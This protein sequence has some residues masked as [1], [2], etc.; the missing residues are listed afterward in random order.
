M[1][2]PGRRGRAWIDHAPILHRDMAT[3]SQYSPLTQLE[4]HDSAGSDEEQPVKNSYS[5][6]GGG[7]R[8]FAVWRCLSRGRATASEVSVYIDSDPCAHC[9]MNI[10]PIPSLN[11]GITLQSSQSRLHDARH[12]TLVNSR[13]RAIPIRSSTLRSA[14]HSHTA[15]P[16][17]YNPRHMHIHHR[18]MLKIRSLVVVMSMPLATDDLSC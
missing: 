17:Q 16:R 11:E 6:A 9:G 3:A 13:G 4:E 18:L 2:A 8:P 15:Q 14:S 7:A 12:T 5:R 10:F 1:R